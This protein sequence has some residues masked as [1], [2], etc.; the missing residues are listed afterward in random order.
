VFAIIHPLSQT[1]SSW[2]FPQFRATE[3]AA[4]EIAAMLR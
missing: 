3:R 4:K 2:L 1:I